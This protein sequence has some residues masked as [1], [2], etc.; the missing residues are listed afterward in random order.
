[1][2]FTDFIYENDKKVIITDFVSGVN[3][4]I[5]KSARTKQVYGVK[6]LSLAQ[7]ASLIVL[8]Y[9]SIYEPDHVYKIISQNVQSMRL[10]MWL[11]KQDI[12]FIP[13]KAKT[14]STSD[15][16][17]SVLNQI[18]YNTP[19]EEFLN[20]TED[21]IVALRNIISE[22]EAM[23]IEH[24]ELDTVMAMREAIEILGIAL[25]KKDSAKFLD[26]LAADLKGSLVGTFFVRKMTV[27]E[28]QFMEMLLK[29]MN[30]PAMELVYEEEPEREYKFFKSYGIANEVRHIKE[31][32]AEQKIPF[33]DVAIIYPAEPYE[34]FMMAE[35]SESSIPFSFPRGFRASN[36]DFIAFMLGLLDFADGDFEYKKLNDFLNNPVIRVSHFSRAYRL[37]L[38]ESIGHT[39]ERYLNFQK[40]YEEL[41]ESSQ[42]KSEDYMPFYQFMMGIIDCFNPD[43]S[44]VQI[45]KSL[46]TLARKYSDKQDVYKKCLSDSLDNYISVFSL[47]ETDSLSES[48]A[49][50]RAFL[51]KLKCSMSENP[52][53]VMILPYGRIETI[54]RKNIFIVG[55]SNENIARTNAES[56]VLCDAELSKY[57]E[58][59]I[60]FA[61]EKNMRNREGWEKTL[62]LSSANC[63]HVSYSHYDTV[64]LIGN[65]PSILFLD[66]LEQ[67]GK[68]EEDVAFVSYQ[69]C[70]DTIHIVD[71]DAIVNVNDQKEVTAQEDSDNKDKEV[72]ASMFSASSLQELIYCPMQYYYEKIAHIPKVQFKD[73]QADRWLMANEK[74]NVFHH[75][76]DQYVTT[77]IIENGKTAFDSQLFEKL[78]ELEI[79]EAIRNNPI[80]SD[81]LFEIEKEECHEALVKY[82]T[83]F[84][85]ELNQSPQNKKVIGCEVAF[86]KI[87]Y[88]N[89]TA[90][91]ANIEHPYT[92]YFSGSVDRLDGFLD[93]NG[94]VWMQ[95][96]D[97]KTGS[98]QKKVKEIE[99]EKQIQHHVYA[100][101]MME[102]AK[103]NVKLLRERFG[104]GVKRVAIHS[105]EY[106]FPYEE[107]DKV[108]P[109]RH[110][111]NQNGKAVL[112]ASVDNML[113][114]V[115]SFYQADEFESALD[116]SMETS[117]E[118]VRAAKALRTDF[119]EYCS[120]KDVCRV[121]GA[122]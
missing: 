65:S 38:K 20:A 121:R 21:K 49:Q 47:V 45:Y 77:A 81:V 91:G 64:G 79:E 41:P 9:K 111:K 51:L 107:E 50:I 14:V 74:G 76:M 15:E 112:P 115:V 29:A 89:I 54:D 18:R 16:I 59:E 42:I 35:F 71:P 82:L 44:C 43:K 99:D 4:L 12:S 75:M 105:I 27:L 92:I 31:V 22:Y 104:D 58:G 70:K 93:E 17:L 53:A 57:A 100:I 13:S 23:L 73:R 25:T 56:P 88:T 110:C 113:Q 85:E 90:D 119:C 66:M 24:S 72:P 101:A 83:D 118:K 109:V 96:Y 8:S 40:R 116:Y 37:F 67:A 1:M 61:L 32:I 39:R 106:H 11:K 98:H 102:W 55:L 6:V 36:C 69:I 26:V 87:P 28:S 84:H 68:K 103:A 97:Y 5:R 60:R 108:L 78:F 30:Q 2:N 120:Y 122:Q 46:L 19:T 33:G 3:K 63:I 62:K 117:I 34:K 95:I 80:P 10:T 86:E 52:G 7:L 114:N 94:V 48:I